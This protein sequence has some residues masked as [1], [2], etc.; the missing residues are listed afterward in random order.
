MDLLNGTRLT[1]VE[2][3]TVSRASDGPGN[4]SHATVQQPAKRNT[5]IEYLSRVRA[6]MLV[7]PV[8]AAMLLA[9]ILWTQDQIKAVL[10]MAALSMLLLWR[11]RYRARL[12]LSVLDE[13]PH[14][15]GNL[16][17]AAAVIATVIALRHEQDMVT[18]FLQN[19]AI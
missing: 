15:L 2:T 17:T 11:G 3:S 10:S 14:I 13:L 18:T 19:A 9:P 12:H 5:V 16:L 1:T 6:W 8:D 7:I 4:T